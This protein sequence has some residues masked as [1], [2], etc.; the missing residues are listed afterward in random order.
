MT[1]TATGGA[2]RPNWGGLSMLMIV[3]FFESCIF[4]IIFA[5]TLRGLGRHTKRGASFLVSSVCGGAVGPVILG[6]VADRIGTR[7]AMCIPLIFFAIAWSYPIYLNVC[8]GKSLDA[9]T[10]SHVGSTDG[11][12]DQDSI[13]ASKDVEA[14][15]FEVK[16]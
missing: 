13:V 8:K 10:E 3:L 12:V 1:A 15:R 16:A 11:A 5:L 6:N 7:H 2:T 9:Y 4:P 14:S